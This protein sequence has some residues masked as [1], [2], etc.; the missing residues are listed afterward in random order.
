[1]AQADL[2]PVIVTDRLTRR[3]GR[4]AAVDELSL[5]V[6]AGSICG[7][8]GANGAGKTTTLKL[9]M[10]L[11]RPNSGR[12]TVLGVD[13]QRLGPTQLAQIGYVSEN[14]QL[15]DW[16]TVRQLLAYCKPFHPT[17]DDALCRPHVSLFGG[18][19][20]LA[21]S[22]AQD[23]SASRLRLRSNDRRYNQ[24]HTIR[25]GARSSTEQLLKYVDAPVA[26]RDCR[27]ITRPS[28]SRARRR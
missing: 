5:T 9:L 7:F 21:N 22:W 16:M 4:V 3:F 13:S 19:P 2:D 12:A 20:V 15:P 1:M 10:N 14:Q 27:V 8:I 17:W 23:A 26:L 18:E 25:T 28:R 24:T 11:I 6:P